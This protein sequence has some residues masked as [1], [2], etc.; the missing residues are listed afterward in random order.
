MNWKVN[1]M[2]ILQNLDNKPNR[3]QIWL[4]I[5]LEL[6]NFGSSMSL[7]PNNPDAV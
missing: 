6:P 4:E 2:E 1:E 7:E 5:G 3:Y